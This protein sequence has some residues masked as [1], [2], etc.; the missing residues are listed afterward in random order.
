MDGQTMADSVGQMY[1]D[2][3]YNVL[4]MDIRGFGNS[5]GKNGMGYLES[6]D[7]WDWLNFL[8]ENYPNK[9]NQI[10]VH[11]VSLGGA[12]TLFLSGLEI[13]G[14]TL[15][16]Q[17]VIGLVDDCGYTSM[18]GI[19]EDLLGSISDVE[20]VSKILGIL[21]KESFTDLIGED[22][23]KELLI[24][25]AGTGLTEETFDTCQNALN[26]LAKCELPILIIHGTEDFL[27]PFENSTEVYNTAMQNEKIPYIQ[28][29][30]AEGENHAF[31]T[32]G[33][34]YNVYEGHVKNFVAQAEKVANGNTVDKESNYQQ[35]KEE[36]TSVITSLIK[37]LKLIKNMIK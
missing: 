35:E 29:F 19:V 2:Q 5:E 28:R 6:L 26:S 9:C 30:V 15:K 1:L 36:K 34:K 17:N 18:M 37:S 11:G 32:L 4:A 21:N 3:G 13:N 8:N 12:T 22:K 7:A 20:L 14:K 25:T 31:I 33:T 16:E 24:K 27:V 10:I 23:I